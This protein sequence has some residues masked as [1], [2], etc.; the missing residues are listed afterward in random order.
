MSPSLIAIAGPLTG[1]TLPLGAPAVSIGRDD[2]NAIR[3]SDPAVSPRHCVLDRAGSGLTIRD[4]DTS[5]ST[6]ST[7]VSVC[8]SWI[9]LFAILL[10]LGY[11]T[12]SSEVYSRKL[13]FTWVLVT[14]VLLVATQIGIEL[15]MARL[16]GKR[17]RA[18]KVVIAGANELGV[19]L[20]KKI[21]SSR[22][23]GMTVAGFLDDRSSE[24]RHDLQIDPA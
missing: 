16:A 12:K 2:G 14:P 21:R 24:R 9:L 11:A 10:V 1:T 7:A 4:L 8:A 13:L 22:H 5:R 19:T 6:W 15:L 20:A 18:R 23:S 17:N 3:L